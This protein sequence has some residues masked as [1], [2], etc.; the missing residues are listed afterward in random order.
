MGLLH[1]LLVLPQ[2][3][4]VEAPTTSGPGL[5]VVA[6][7]H[8]LDRANRHIVKDSELGHRAVVHHV[9]LHDDRLLSPTDLADSR[10]RSRLP[11]KILQTVVVR[12][13]AASWSRSVS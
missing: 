8:V 2:I 3:L 10:H 6:P 13:E 1:F 4:A 7:Q 11:A 5:N 12:A 9:R